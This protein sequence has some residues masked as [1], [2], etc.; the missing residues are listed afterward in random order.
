M[1]PVLPG[2]I[3]GLV[4][5][6]MVLGPVLPGS[7]L[8]LVLPDLVLGRADLPVVPGIGVFD[9][10]GWFCTDMVLFVV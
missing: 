1:G 5:P 8:G 2:S 10:I 7:I 6:E 4:L 3:S 9:G